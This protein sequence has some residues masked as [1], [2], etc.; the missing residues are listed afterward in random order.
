MK[1]DIDPPQLQA[2]VDGELELGRRLEIEQRM[3]DDPSIRRQ[4]DEL[5]DLRTAVRGHAEYHTAPEELR[6]RFGTV[7]RSA[8]P[9]RRGRWF[10]GWSGTPGLRPWAAAF[11]VVIVASLAVQMLVARN[12]AETRLRD[13]VVA[14]HVR[15]TIGDRLVDVASSDHHTVKPW[16]SSKLD[17]SPPVRDTQL[18]D[19]TFSGARVD[20]L[21]GRPVA[22]LVYRK[23]GHT[24]D[25]YVWPTVSSDTEPVYSTSR[26][27]QIA[28]WSRAGM[29]WWT[30]SDVN[31]AEFGDFV[32]NLVAEP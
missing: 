2:F 14:S 30:I 25:A 6:R 16:L 28:R 15:A 12:G 9:A 10:D 11:T 5:R 32:K 7:G 27:F 20:Y 3:A 22:A 18:G 13:D 17:F 8:A 19:A 31:R 26:G 21:D 24:V 4:V 1:P 23:G 29:T